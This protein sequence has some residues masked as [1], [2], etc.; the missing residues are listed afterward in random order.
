ML[1]MS[2]SIIIDSF[3]RPDDRDLFVHCYDHK[4][5]HNWCG[6]CC[7]FFCSWTNRGRLFAEDRG[8]CCMS[9]CWNWDIVKS[10]CV[11]VFN[12]MVIVLV[13]ALIILCALIIG[14]P[15]ILVFIIVF[16][17]LVVL[18]CVCGCCG[19]RVK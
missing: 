8:E 4:A 1:C 2:K 7:C 5:H 15:L 16:I 10:S 17:V 18:G 3:D 6:K 11:S 9:I 19:V 13:I 12:Y 14:I